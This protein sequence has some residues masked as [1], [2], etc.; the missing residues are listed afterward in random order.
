MPIFEYQ[1]ECGNVF[2]KLEMSSRPE[3]VECKKCGKMS[4]R[5][6]SSCSF[7]VKGFNANNCYSGGKE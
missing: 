7:D 5:I 4:K 2:E 3:M 6:M 1:C